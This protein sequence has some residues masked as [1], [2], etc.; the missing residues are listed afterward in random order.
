MGLTPNAANAQRAKPDRNRRIYELSLLGE[1][2]QGLAPKFGL[3]AGR[4]G[5]L[6]RKEAQRRRM[7]EEPWGDDWLRG[8]A[9]AALDAGLADEPEERNGKIYL[10]VLL[11]HGTHAE[12]A[13]PFYI[14]EGTVRWIVD[15][16]EKRRR[17][18]GEP[19]GDDLLREYARLAW[20]EDLEP[21]E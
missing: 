11:Q 7:A 2:E 5:Q 4:I 18:A 10:R 21:I 20:L 19:L 9:R 17:K 12:I 14:A 3:T 16:E 13:E 8:M 15:E 6:K 1:T